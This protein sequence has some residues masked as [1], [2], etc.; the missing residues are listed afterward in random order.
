MSMTT[1][2][3]GIVPPDAK[4][5]EMKAV[6]DSCTKAGVPVP[7]KVSTFFNDENPD[8]AG[9]VV[10]LY[11]SPAVKEWNAEDEQGLE[12]ELAKLPPHIKFLRFCNSY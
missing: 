7:E 9:V 6:W 3:V 5:R 11:K 4:W 2:V 12:V 1:S 8:E 10:D